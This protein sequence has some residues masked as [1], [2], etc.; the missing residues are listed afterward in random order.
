MSYLFNIIPEKHNVKLKF[1]LVG[2]WNTIFGYLVF[3]LLE[4]LFSLYISPQYI[5]Y[6]SASVLG[7]I[8]AVIN[9]F[10]FH[11]YLTFKS[12]AKGRELIKEFFRFTMTYGFTFCLNL[13]L[14]PFFV[15][16]FHITPKVSAG[17][18]IF[19]V[20]PINYFGHSR[21]SFKK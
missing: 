9:A 8:V 4:T 5:S 21:F 11:K 7:Q 19:I 13:A 3:I 20:L 6:M 2:I 17:I 15:E 12:S 14:L 16:I 18:I 1:V 10:V